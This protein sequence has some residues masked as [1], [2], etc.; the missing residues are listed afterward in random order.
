MAVERSQ[1]SLRVVAAELVVQ[2]DAHD[3]EIF[4]VIASSRVWA[5]LKGLRT[6]PVPRIRAQS[7]SPRS[8]IA[9]SRL[10]TVSQIGSMKVRSQAP[11][12]RAGSWF[13]RS[14]RLAFPPDQHTITYVMIVL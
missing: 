4:P 2:A 9:S 3:V 13:C 5:Q 8:R 11:F 10:D 14:S 1:R 12:H 7:Q 6:E